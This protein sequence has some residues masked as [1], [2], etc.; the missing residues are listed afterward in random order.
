MDIT[1]RKRAQEQMEESLLEKTRALAAE[2]AAREASR[3]KSEFLAN[4]SHEIRTPIAGVIGL[5][6]L[7]LDEKGLTPQHRDY[8]ETIQRSAEGL[9]TVINDVLD[10][11]KV[12]IGKLDV[13]QAPF[14]LEVLLRDAKRMLSFATQKKKLDFRDSVELTYRGQLIGDVG[15]LRQ[16]IT[17][18]LTNAIKFTAR[19][20]ISLEVAELS[21]D[22]GNLLVR[23]DVRDTGCGI[24]SESLSRLFQPFSQADPST[25]RRFGGT[26]LGL[27]ISKNL[28]E[29]M[30]GE[31]GLNSVEGQGSH[32]WFVIPFRKAS[33]Q[34]DEER[35][36]ILEANVESP[37]SSSGYGTGGIPIIEKTHLTR[38]RKDIWILIAEDN[39]VNAQI[40]SKN[41]KK[42]GFSCRTAENGILA[43]EELNKNSYDAVL[44]DCQMPECD[45]YEA[46]R[47]IRKSL[48]PDIRI[49]PVI[50]LTA[51][52]IKGDRERAID[53]G[54]V[55]Y[56]AKPVK[57]PALESTLCKWLF[58]HDARQSLAR[59]FSTT[60]VSPKNSHQGRGSNAT[61]RQSPISTIK[62]N[63]SVQVEGQINTVSLGVDDKRYPAMEL[64]Q[65]SSNL[66]SSTSVHQRTKSENT[67]QSTRGEGGST[68]TRP[69]RL[70][71]S[72]IL[73]GE[74]L[75]NL[76]S[77]GASNAEHETSFFRN[78]EA[79]TAAAVL[80]SARRS[81]A[82]DVSIKSL[83]D[84]NKVIRPGLL[85]RSIS[86]GGGSP[87]TG[88]IQS[89]QS[90]ASSST[91]IPAEFSFK[92]TQWGREEST[93]R[94]DMFRRSTRGQAGL[95]RDLEGEVFQATFAEEPRLGKA[96][97]NSEESLTNKD[98][99]D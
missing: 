86:H 30:N 60:P 39:I 79:L 19:G 97:L 94:P 48:N 13:E 27:S 99:D 71:P 54:M 24:N 63:E 56:L 96:A 72:G 75:E 31:I 16:V 95:G 20:Y 57:R 93:G 36:R 73:S 87:S 43:L 47:M 10:F 49:L 85:P 5:S 29:L 88:S 40:A 46:T 78:G 21:E 1:D 92:S 91:S 9:L 35:N 37:G 18:L 4:M 8:A 66:P 12:E 50:A 52:A 81:S 84:Q 64:G 34:E 2:G 61:V 74:V 38:P 3:L 89:S 98:N 70:S 6:E 23:F 67:Y 69:R 14:N 90:T 51:S 22:E 45:G 80:L 7:L 82:T 77:P 62:W 41:I 44:M 26:G 25:A 83:S 58:D 68:S 28:V 17:N 59:F 76:K 53:A 65:V 42:M 32:A 11:S 15:R 33:Q 55:D